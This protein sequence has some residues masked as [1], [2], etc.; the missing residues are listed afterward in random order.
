MHLQHRLGLSLLG[1]ERIALRL[2][3]TS[4]VRAFRKRYAWNVDV[5]G[6]ARFLGIVVLSHVACAT[7]A[8]GVHLRFERRR[9]GEVPGD[10]LI[11]LHGHVSCSALVTEMRIVGGQAYQHHLV[12]ERSC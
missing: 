5:L 9:C 4:M 2:T 3:S 10:A 1:N 12:L 8:G 6:G 11:G 7:S